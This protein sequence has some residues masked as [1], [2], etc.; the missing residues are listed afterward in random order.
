MGIESAE[1]IGTMVLESFRGID[2]DE[3]EDDQLRCVNVALS[4][5]ES[6]RC[7][8]CP[9][10]VCRLILGGFIWIAGEN[11]Y[12]GVTMS[13]E[14]VWFDTFAQ[15]TAAG[16]TYRGSEC[17]P[18]LIDWA[19]QGDVAYYASQFTE[20]D[21]ATAHAED[22]GRVVPNQDDRDFAADIHAQYVSNNWQ[23]GFYTATTTTSQIETSRAY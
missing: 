2:L 23:R 3:N 1:Y 12:L 15:A 16:L 21:L 5:S 7:E 6:G 4:V 11:Q 18:C 13:E 20:E 22:N 9:P 14:P 17:S 10:P 8:D 19:V